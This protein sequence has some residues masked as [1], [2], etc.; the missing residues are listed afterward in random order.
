MPLRVPPRPLIARRDWL[1]LLVA[2][3]RTSD[4]LDPVRIQKG[5]FLLAQE[6]DLLEGERYGFKAYNYGP[7]S[8]DVYRDLDV[9]LDTRHCRALPVPGYA[10]VRYRSTD[11]GGVRAAKVK[12]QVAEQSPTTLARLGDI[13]QILASKNFGDL[14]THVYERY[15]RYASR[16]VFRNR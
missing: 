7:M 12:R 4:G 1:L 6:G 16:S 10:W 9:L 2:E 5:L 14:L 3:A 8:V 11:R 13:E 15:P